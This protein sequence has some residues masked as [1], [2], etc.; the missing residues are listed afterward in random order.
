M[1]SIKFTA[2]VSDIKGKANGSVFSKNKQGNYFRNNVTGGGRKSLAWDQ[3]KSNFS[4]LATQWR[5]L[6]PVQKDSWD[7]MA[8]NY[9]ALNKF[10]ESYIPSG[11]Q[12]YMRLNGVLYAKGFSILST[13]IAQR[14]FPNLEELY[15]DSPSYSAYTGKWGAGFNNPSAINVVGNN[16]YCPQ[17]YVQG[18]TDCEIGMPEIDFL[19]C[20]NNLQLNRQLGCSTGC[21]TAADCETQG[22]TAPNNEVCCQD[23]VCNWCGD[24]VVNMFQGAYLLNVAPA[25]KDG[26]I[27][28]NTF[29]DDYVTFNLSFRLWLDANAINGVRTNNVP[30]V[31]VSNYKDNAK[32]LW[33]RLCPFDANNA[34]VEW[35]MGLV[36]VAHDNTE[37]TNAMIGIVP[38][39]ILQ[40]QSNVWYFQ[41]NLNNY[42]DFV[43]LIGWDNNISWLACNTTKK[44]NLK[45]NFDW[46][47]LGVKGWSSLPWNCKDDEWGIMLGAFSYARQW[48]MN[49]SDFRWNNGTYT[50]D[51]RMFITQGYVVPGVQVICAMALFEVEDCCNKVCS[52]LGP[53][54]WNCSTG[55]STGSCSCGGSGN[56]D[57]GWCLTTNT[58]GLANFGSQSSN[59]PSFQFVCPAYNF[60]NSEEG[61]YSLI[62]NGNCL[63][64][65]TYPTMQNN[66][67]FA[68]SFDINL[69]LVSE[70]NFFLIVNASKPMTNSSVNKGTSHIGTLRL[71]VGRSVNIWDWIIESIGNF[72]DYSSCLIKLQILDSESGQVLNFE[73]QYLERENELLLKEVDDTGKKK[74]KKP[75]TGNSVRF[76]AGSDLSSS[77]N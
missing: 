77:V 48:G 59:V 58:R 19:N 12:L 62:Y 25:I 71:G 32:N 1:P 20:F 74:K 46:D 11:F 72:P 35:G 18:G 3:Q 42:Q 33:V 30:V 65:G 5:S 23:G 36:D 24:G 44:V 7:S 16:A 73:T 38:Y 47:G 29:E 57:E 28:D 4:Y 75:K 26:G 70:D 49:F 76:K 66:A 40:E 64:Y 60:T 2:L 67:I 9:P 52:N 27:I 14:S 31:I 56:P 17:C 54:Q 55:A 68:P 37:F 13:P 15:V 45:D 43:G 53:C 10:K 69:P 6:T 8:A 51:E 22:M 34:Q 50:E 61:D 39:A 21:T 41:Y 63:P